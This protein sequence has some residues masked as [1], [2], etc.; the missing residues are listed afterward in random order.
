MN[1]CLATVTGIDDEGGLSVPGVEKLIGE[2]ASYSFPFFNFNSNESIKFTNLWKIIQQQPINNI[3]QLACFEYT[4]E[5]MNY[6][7]MNVTFKEIKCE[8]IILV[9]SQQEDTSNISKSNIIEDFMINDI[10]F[11]SVSQAIKNG[12]HENIKHCIMHSDNNYHK[13][14]ELYSILFLE[15]K[16]DSCNRFFVAYAVKS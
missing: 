3:T 5:N 13:E 15:N 1:F 10:S 2:A 8:N 6:E 14:N 16:S 4:P 11:Y 12:I 7:K 9:G